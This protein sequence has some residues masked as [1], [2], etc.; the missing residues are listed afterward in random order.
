M[1]RVGVVV[2][3]DGDDEVGDEA[4]EPFEIV[5]L[6]IAQEASNDQDSKDQDDGLEGLERQTHVL[7]ETPADEDNNGRVKHDRLNACSKD[8]GKR[9]VHLIVVRLIDGRQVFSRLLDNG[10]Q[11]KTDESILDMAHLDDVVDLVDKEVRNA[12]DASDGDG[13][14]D[15]ALSQRELVLL[16]IFVA[17]L[18]FQLVVFENLVVQSMVGVRLEPDI[19]DMEQ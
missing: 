18:V 15:E 2:G 11:D 10:N 3:T 19:A 1:S 17:I 7:A 13:E 16:E 9:E 8:V 6:T 14:S 12:A 4:Q 5:A